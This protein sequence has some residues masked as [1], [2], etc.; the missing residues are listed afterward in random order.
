MDVV[1]SVN[2]TLVNLNVC[3]RNIRPRYIADYL[4]PPTSDDNSSKL[5]L[6]NLYLFQHNLLKTTYIQT[7]FI[8]VSE[9]CPISNKDVI[10]YYVDYLGGFFYNQYHNCAIV[11][12]PGAVSQGD[13]VEI[14]ATANWFGPYIIPEGFYPISSF[15]WISAN[16]RFKV[17][18]YLIMNH[19]A[20]IRSLDDVNYLHVLQVHSHDCSVT[21]N[22]LMSTISYGVYFDNEIRYCVLATNHFCSYCQ[23]KGVKDIPEYLLAC[24]CNYY[25]SVSQ[26]WIAEVCFCPS[27]TDCTKVTHAF[28]TVNHTFT[29]LAS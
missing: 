23:A 4:S 7:N 19:Y 1:L 17:P 22:L 26:S 16:Y 13:C 29:I 27:N 3:G 18:V 12:P 6:Q 5:S 20:K 21:E 15:L 2:Q 8:K 25:D 9:T 24:Y 14:Q 11:I 10:S 28:K